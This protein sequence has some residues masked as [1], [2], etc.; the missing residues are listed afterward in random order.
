MGRTGKVTKECWQEKKQ[1]EWKDKYE[2]GKGKS[3][4]L[5]TVWARV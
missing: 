2:E 3:I 5:K 1:Y 4:I